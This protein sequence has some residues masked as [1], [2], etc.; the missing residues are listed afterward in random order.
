MSQHVYDAIVGDRKIEVFMGWDR[1]LQGFFMVL[2]EDGADD[3]L[4][5]NLYEPVTHPKTLDR[6][7]EV[8]AGLGI[9]L[10]D[11]MIAEMEQDKLDNA[12]NKLVQH[13]VEDGKYERIGPAL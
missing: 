6:F 5:S 3:Y 8:L 11:E 4:F 2:E 12:G 13:R 1:P 10:P 7:I 9:A